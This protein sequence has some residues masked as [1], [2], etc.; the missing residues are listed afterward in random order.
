MTLSIRNSRKF[1]FKKFSENS[2]MEETLDVEGR[3]YLEE[4][5]LT[6]TNSSRGTLS[7]LPMK[8]KP[9]GEY[10]AADGKF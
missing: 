10:S 8:A 6:E 9:T 7:P 5:S 1:I 2:K 3:Y 4:V